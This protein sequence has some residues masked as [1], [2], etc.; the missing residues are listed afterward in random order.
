M[1]PG[2]AY[3]FLSEHI[4]D[5]IAIS[6][7]T[8][9]RPVGRF[10]L[11]QRPQSTSVP[12]RIIVHA[13]TEH[14]LWLN[15]RLIAFAVLSIILGTMINGIIP[16][17]RPEL[18]IVTTVII[19]L[20]AWL[21]Q[22]SATHIL[23]KVMRG[24]GTYPETLSVSLQVASVLYVASNFLALVVSAAVTIPT[25]E[26]T[27]EGFFSIGALIAKQPIYSFFLCHAILSTV[28]VPMAMKAVHR[29]GMIRTAILV[30]ISG[31]ASWLTVDFGTAVY[32]YVGLMWSNVMGSGIG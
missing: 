1:D 20:L 16:E 5:F 7:E 27:V 25:V 2:K 18:G 22:G 15:P 21:F 3:T 31:L 6:V 4:S 19:I 8:F 12:S 24:R 13:K 29:F 26:A 32:E 23:C 17:R 9:M 14:E 30:A 11:V 10:E 28:Y